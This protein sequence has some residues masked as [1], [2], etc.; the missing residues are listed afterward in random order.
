MFSKWAHFSNFKQ[1]IIS[2]IFFFLTKLANLIHTE[3]RTH[4]YWQAQLRLKSLQV[5]CSAPLDHKEDL[6]TKILTRILSTTKPPGPSILETKTYADFSNVNKLGCTTNHYQKKNRHKHQNRDTKWLCLY[7]PFPVLILSSINPLWPRWKK[8]SMFK[9]CSK[10]CDFV[11][12]CTCYKKKI[13]N[14]R[15]VHPP[16]LL[17]KNT[18]NTKNK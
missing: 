7:C 15:G 5:L 16:L 4:W 9:I 18:K 10:N 17:V 6:N 14:K 13:K 1:S 3:Y 2:D 8:N 11:P 12:Y